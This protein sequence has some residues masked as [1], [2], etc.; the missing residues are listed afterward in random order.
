VI[1]VKLRRQVTDV[2]TIV[3]ET[4]EAGLVQGI[5]F[6][7]AYYQARHDPVNGHLISEPYTIFSFYGRGDYALIFKLKYGE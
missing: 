6:D 2:L 7:F 1:E 3:S 4:K 5:D